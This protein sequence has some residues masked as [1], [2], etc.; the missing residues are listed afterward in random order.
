M[1]CATR[2][3]A[4]VVREREITLQNKS[5]FILCR[6]ISNISVSS[7]YASFNWVKTKLDSW[8]LGIV[9]FVEYISVGELPF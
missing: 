9:S 7:R 1:N 6:R 2:A 4:N 3:S 8:L 5:D